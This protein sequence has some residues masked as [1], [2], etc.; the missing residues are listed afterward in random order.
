VY[1]ADQFNLVLIIINS[2]VRIHAYGRDMCR[3]Q[4]EPGGAG[5][6]EHI[7]EAQVA[8]EKDYWIPGTA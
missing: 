4:A 1:A 6:H 8:G 5:R 7:E 3:L 2:C